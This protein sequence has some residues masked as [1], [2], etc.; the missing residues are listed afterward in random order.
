M[1]FMVHFHNADMISMEL[2]LQKSKEQCAHYCFSIKF[3]IGTDL[4]RSIY[5]D[6]N[7]NHF[8]EK[9]QQTITLNEGKY[10]KILAFLNF[11]YL[12]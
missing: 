5:N 8:Q 4:G 9:R 10:A 3:K 11:G 1:F 2:R 12:K 6:C 7:T